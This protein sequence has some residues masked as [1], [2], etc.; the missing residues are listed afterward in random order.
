MNLETQSQTNTNLNKTTDSDRPL[1]SQ[2]FEQEELEIPA[3]DIDVLFEKA[4]CGS[5]TTKMGLYQKVSAFLMLLTMN[6]GGLFFYGIPFY[7]K[8]PTYLC[9]DGKMDQN[10][11]QIWF[12]CT[13]E[14]VCEHT[15]DQYKTDLTPKDNF[16]ALVQ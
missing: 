4:G 2:T 10:G 7:E 11:K 8:I 16:V 5:K 3:D 9:S 6:S 12:N 1:L 13:A 15:F 14:Q